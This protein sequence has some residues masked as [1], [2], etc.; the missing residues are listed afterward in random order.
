MP[1]SSEPR[2]TESPD[3]SLVLG[4]P[5]Y[6]L[7]RRSRLTGDTLELLH[8]RIIVLTAVAWV[9]LLLLSFAEGA[10]WGGRVTL[11]FLYDVDMHIRL[12]LALPLL[13]VAELVVHLRLRPTVRAFVDRGVIP[14]AARA[15]FDALIGSGMRLRN[16]VSVE[17]LLIAFVYVVGVGFIW[18]TQG[19]LAV[20]TWCG[21]P[22]KGMR[23]APFTL[24]TVL[25][26]AVVTL[27][28]V[29]PLT[30]T[31]ISLE[32]LLTKAVRMLF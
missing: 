19:A 30:L 20:A 2:L 12:L 17:V 28:P 6:Q 9:P 4:G 5:L 15:R 23:L 7:W 1:T 22:V 18:R 16:S 24:R 25:Q 3:F 10:A 8:R 21:A 29:V 31:M 14:D 13:I 26:L 11:P 32:E 27:I